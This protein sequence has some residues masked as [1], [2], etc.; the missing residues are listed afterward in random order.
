MQVFMMIP[1]GL[2][3]AI[4]QITKGR[5]NIGAKSVVI[6]MTDG[7]WNNGGDPLPEV[8]IIKDKLKVSKLVLVTVS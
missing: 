2:K 8:N 3:L 5:K 1:S 6:F 7:D 4:E